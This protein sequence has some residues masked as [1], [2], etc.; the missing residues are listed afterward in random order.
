[1]T[2]AQTSR[3]GA[4]LTVERRSPARRHRLQPVELVQLLAIIPILVIVDLV[5]ASS[6][7]QWFDY[8]S[9][10]A[11]F[12][13]PEGSLRP[14]DLFFY[15]EGHVPAIPGLI[16]WLNVQLTGGLAHALGYYD[17]AVVI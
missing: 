3:S 15:S 11:R 6:Q 1:M 12:M 2:S 14:L 17:V 4:P 5:Q 13:G 16:A 7:L 8:W 10:L 9:A